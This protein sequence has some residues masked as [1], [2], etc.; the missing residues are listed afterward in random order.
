MRVSVPNEVN[1]T[2]PNKKVNGKWKV[3][4]EFELVCEIV[5]GKPQGFSKIDWYFKKHNSEKSIPLDKI[6][7]VKPFV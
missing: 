1:L 6:L 2:S 4:D 3:G 7:N 5:N